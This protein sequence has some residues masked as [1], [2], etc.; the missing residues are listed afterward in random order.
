MVQVKICG[1][2]NWP[3]AKRAADAGADLLGFNFY[4]GSPRYIEPR[5]A[6]RIIRQL[7]AR[8]TP[9]GVFVNDLPGAVVELAEYT[10]VRVAQL[11]G[12]ESPAATR[13]IAAHLPVIKAFRARRG[14]RLARLGQYTAAF[15]LLLDGFSIRFRG[16]T[17]KTFDW[18]LARTARRYGRVFL[19]GGL[20]PENVGEAMRRAR[21]YG[22]DVC[23]GVESRPGKKS[24]RKLCALFDAI[25][26]AR[27]G[28]RGRKSE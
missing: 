3:D 5:R 4:P 20:T 19:A 15:A 11:H 1:I 17:G 22:V 9:V 7:P 12:E 26:R 14:F 28:P 18:R 16:G 2:T 21:P 8:V 10:G 6:R 27:R 24:G 13:H 23:T 25:E